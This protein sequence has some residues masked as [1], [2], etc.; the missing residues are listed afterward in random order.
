[1]AL[2]AKFDD[3]IEI[4]NWFKLKYQWKSGMIEWLCNTSSGTPQTH[5]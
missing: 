2:N 3:F 4:L 1:M 5:I